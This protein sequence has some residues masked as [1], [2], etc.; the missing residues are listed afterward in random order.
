MQI[1]SSGLSADPTSACRLAVPS[2]VPSAA[3]AAA[4]GHRGRALGGDGVPE[5]AEPLAVGLAGR[6]VTAEGVERVTVVGDL[7]GAVAAGG[8]AEH[9]GV[10][11]AGR[12]GA[13]GGGEGRPRAGA[14]IDAGA[15]RAGVAL[16][17]VEGAAVAVDEDRAEVADL[18]G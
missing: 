11:T 14:R 2:A 1:P 17:Q 5:V 9:G 12:G 8:G 10:G 4:V 3:V 16:E 6:G 18:R 7:G 15:G 13:A